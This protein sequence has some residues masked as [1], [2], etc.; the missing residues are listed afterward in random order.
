MED[1]SPRD[2]FNE[3]RNWFSE[4]WNNRSIIVELRAKTL[5]PFIFLSSFSE[6]KTGS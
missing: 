4:A 3:G 5:G 2:E 6:H 1:K